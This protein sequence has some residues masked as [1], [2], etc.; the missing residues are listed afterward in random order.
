MRSDPSDQFAHNFSLI[1]VSF[2]RDENFAKRSR[3]NDISH[4]VSRQRSTDSNQLKR[5]I[6]RLGKARNQ[7][8]HADS[9]I[10]ITKS[11]NECRVSFPDN[12]IQLVEWFVLTNMIKC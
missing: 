4:E 10:Q 6:G 7:T 3:L 5:H 2:D 8:S 12:M 1:I 11:S 9:I